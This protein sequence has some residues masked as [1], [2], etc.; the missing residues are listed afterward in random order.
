MS[1]PDARQRREVR[2][3]RALYALAGAVTVAATSGGL[4]FAYPE[5]LG[6]TRGA[7]V[8]LHDLSGDAAVAL[9]VG[10]LWLHLPR[11]WPMRRQ[12]VSRWTGLGSVAV[13]GIAAV[14]GLMGQV[15]PLEGWPRALHLGTSVGILVLVSFHGA[16]AYR[17]RRPRT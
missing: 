16:W 15:G 14:T 12:R 10:Y 1:P 13:W 3:H 7:F 9:S 17:P 8:W 6:A 5:T 11:T 2:A 4:L